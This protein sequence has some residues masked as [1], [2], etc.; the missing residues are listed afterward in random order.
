MG[1]VIGETSVIGDG[2]ILYK[3]VVLGGTNTQRAV[4][5]PELGQK[6]VVGSNACILGHIRVG[7]G[8][9]IGSGSVVIRDVPEQATVV[10]VPGRVVPPKGDPRRRFHAALDHADLPDPVNEMLRSLRDQNERLRRRIARLEA[11][12]SINAEEHHAEDDVSGAF[13][14][15]DLPP[16]HGG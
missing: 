7:D 3:G 8:A 5:H 10:G 14:T 9:R 6:V 16:Q 11:A 2:C 15:S 1:V 13:V 4:R 12:L